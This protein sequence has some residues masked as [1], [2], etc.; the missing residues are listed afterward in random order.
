[1]STSQH[2]DLDPTVEYYNKNAKAFIERSLDADMSEAYGRFLSLLPCGCRVLDAGCGTGR[3]AKYFLEQG[4]EVEAF[5]AS[6]EMVKYAS[7]HAGIEVQQF[8]FDQLEYSDEFDAVWACA[9][10]LH[11]LKDDINSVFA[12]L[13]HALRSGGV[14]YLS[15]KE[16]ESD[17]PAD[18]RNF[19]YYSLTELKHIVSHQEDVEVLDIWT[20]E[21][22]RC[23]WINTIIAKANLD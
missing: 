16:G 3:D 9:S 12:R 23:V 15:V 21:S 18:G 5:D 22:D 6:I 17:T 14:M 10:L 2:S 19:S 20:S 13:V 4:Y 1:M 7:E 11:V 8:R